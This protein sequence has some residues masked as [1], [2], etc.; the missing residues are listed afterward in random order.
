[1]AGR[2][3]VL[4]QAC[5]GFHADDLA[6]HFGFPFVLCDFGLLVYFSRSGEYALQT[7]IFVSESWLEIGSMNRLAQISLPLAPVRTS[8]ST[9][10]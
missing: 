1:M 8:D 4:E 7:R 3:I 5:E 9:L 10:A 2:R 6:L